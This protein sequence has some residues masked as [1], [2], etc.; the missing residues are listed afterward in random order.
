LVHN[1]GEECELL[2]NAAK[3]TNLKVGD[4][5]KYSDYLDARKTG[6]TL[7]G[8]HIVQQ[9]RLREM[10]IDPL[11]GT[12]VVMEH[13]S[14]RLTRT[15][16]GRGNVTSLSERGMPLSHSEALDLAD[17]EV[18]ALGAI[19]IDAIKQMNRVNHPRHF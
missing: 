15:Y 11:D 1:A 10:G 6:S 17:P 13:S 14:H 3:D 19:V 9:A 8:H 4:V 7:R 18:Q 5:M 2:R 16:K 12:V